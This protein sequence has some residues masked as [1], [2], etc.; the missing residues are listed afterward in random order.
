MEEPELV[1][2]P[3]PSGDLRRFLVDKVDSHNI[4]RTGDAEWS[5]V[6]FFLRTRQGEWV[7]G[8]TGMV[9]GRWLHVQLLWVAPSFRG[10]GQGSRLLR[11]AEDFAL[12][13]GAVAATLE[14]FSFQAPFFYLARGYEVFGTLDDYPPGH[15]KFFLRKQLHH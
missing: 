2:E 6:G 8:L 7:G 15:H 12:E 5:P 14:T 3:L 4:A 13:Q 11:G 1:F 10:Q 9:W